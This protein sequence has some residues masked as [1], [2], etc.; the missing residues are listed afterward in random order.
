MY[1]P[2][3]GA[4]PL[5][6][7][8]VLLLTGFS[9]NFGGDKC[10]EA[11]ELAEKLPTVADPQARSASEERIRS[12][13]PDGAAAHF[14]QGVQAERAGNLDGAIAAY[15]RALL[16][17]P[18][19]AVANGNL[20]VLYLERGLAD[21]AAVVLTKALAT[22]PLP[23]YHKAM[24][25]ILA[26]KKFHALAQYH[27]GEAIRKAPS[28]AASLVGQAE[29]YAAQGQ[30]DRAVDELKRALILDPAS[31]QATVA[32]ATLYLQQN[33][34]DEAFETLKKGTTANPRSSRLHLMLADLYETRGDSKQAEYERLLG[35]KK[36]AQ[37]E[38]QSTAPQPEGL[39]QADRFAEAGDL[40]KAVEAYQAFMRQQPDAI[41]P[42]E[43]LGTLYY[44]AGRDGDAILAYRE[45]VH[46][47][48]TRPEIYYNLG[49]LYEK[50][51]QLDEAV[52]SYKRA[53][54][55]NP[56]FAEAR[57]KLAEI[58]YSR[59]NIQ[60]AIEQYVEF[61]KLKPESAD[62]HL[63]L[64]RIFVRNKSLNLAEDSYKAVLG[65]NPDNPDANRELAAVYRTKGM[66]EQAVKHYRKVLEI[67][68]DDS[69]T[70]NA[71]VALYV[72]EKQYDEL[73]A[74][75][76]ETVEQDPDDPNNH[77]KLGLIYDFKKDYENA[78]QCYQKAIALKADHARA[79]HALGRVYI[80]T[81]RLSEAR[82]ALEAARKADPGMEE[83]AVLLNNIRDDF[84]PVPR[85]S[86]KSKK[87]KK[88]TAKKAA[89]KPKS[90]SANKSAAPAKK[91]AR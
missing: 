67:Q 16:Q 52:V 20:G 64:A 63:K 22:Q 30:T 54:E 73:V 80:K 21:D 59:G 87:G 29:S 37:P 14:V 28:D 10:R 33:R 85:K 6:A 82:E 62:I 68:K 65:L 4:L 90:G 83:T 36:V 45:A 77:Y 53:V 76:K 46:R 57:L 60:E 61:L 74:L 44:K 75:L 39:A 88:G 7:A 8:A 25:K 11:L 81:G 71:L 56:S 1:R 38:P 3:T 42:H 17:E 9:W 91:T 43:R 15:R 50:R 23:A 5:L 86:A 24:G 19:L 13:C 34:Q 84:K 41:E 18:N 27:F 26:D 66:H 89:N 47:G 51:N 12:L 31:E 72:K 55:R 70:R 2:F 49:Q 48:S 35:G 78:A 32:L 69:D 40:E 58:R 79:L